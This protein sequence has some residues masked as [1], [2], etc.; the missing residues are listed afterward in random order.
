MSK[1]RKKLQIS[2]GKKMKKATKTSEK[3]PT[4]VSKKT[5]KAFH[6]KFGPGKPK[7]CREDNTRVEPTVETLPTSR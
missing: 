5:T 2:G 6:F 4:K 7:S 3:K 1:C